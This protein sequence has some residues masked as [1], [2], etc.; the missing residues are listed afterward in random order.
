M[1]EFAVQARK[2]VSSSKEM[3]SASSFDAS[4][5]DEVNL[6][7]EPLL[8]GATGS[9]A[10]GQGG[11]MNRATSNFGALANSA[12][13]NGALGGT[14]PSQ[15]AP[16]GATPHSGLNTMRYTTL[17]SAGGANANFGASLGGR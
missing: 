14:M 8:G 11:N 4:R 7:D 13:V 2:A 1:H 3:S 17:N 15:P 5:E 6:I 12:G 10:A 16:G 9:K